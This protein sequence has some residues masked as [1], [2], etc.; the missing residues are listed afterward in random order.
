MT[1]QHKHLNPFFFANAMF[2]TNWKELML[3]F[4]IDLN[5]CNMIL[6]AN[7]KGKCKDSNYSPLVLRKFILLSLQESLSKEN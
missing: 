2:E 7:C 4:N 6:S 5:L 3:G 1:A